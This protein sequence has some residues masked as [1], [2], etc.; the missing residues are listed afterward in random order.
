MGINSKPNRKDEKAPYVLI[1]EIVLN[2]SGGSL[3]HLFLTE[4]TNPYIWQ[5]WEGENVGGARVCYKPDHAKEF[6]T[7]SQ[8]ESASKEIGFGFTPISKADALAKFGTHQFEE[9]KEDRDFR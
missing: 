9:R 4:S 2:K 5:E 8:A 6:R 7:L 3:R 1:S